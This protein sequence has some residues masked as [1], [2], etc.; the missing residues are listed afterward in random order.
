MNFNGSKLGLKISKFNV[1]LQ[2]I[3]LSTNR[4]TESILDIK[5]RPLGASFYKTLHAPQVEPMS[6]KNILN[7]VGL[8]SHLEWDAQW[9]LLQLP[10]ENFKGYPRE[11]TEREGFP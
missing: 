11:K 9:V 5:D 10:L 3:Q 7:K 8:I 4:I 2:R 6:T 1:G